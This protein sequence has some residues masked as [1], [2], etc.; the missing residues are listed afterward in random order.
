MSRDP[1]SRARWVQL[2]ES[3]PNTPDAL[4][5]PES[6]A[7]PRIDAAVT[8]E[9]LSILQELLSEFPMRPW[10]AVPDIDGHQCPTQ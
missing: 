9:D 7:D 10:S 2:R 6:S 1:V 3:P 5:E 8:T 4:D